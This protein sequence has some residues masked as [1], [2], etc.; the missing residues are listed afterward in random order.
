MSDIKPS[1]LRIYI[2]NFKSLCKD[3]DLETPINEPLEQLLPFDQYLKY[4]ESKEISTR[5]GRH[6]A[7]LYF[8]KKNNE[9]KRY[10]KKLEEY[11]DIIKENYPKKTD[12]GKS[13]S[14]LQPEMNKYMTLYDS[15]LSKFRSD[16]ST[17]NFIFLWVLYPLKDPNMPASRNIL[18]SVRYGKFKSGN[19][20]SPRDK[21]LYLRDHKSDKYH[22]D[23]DIDVPLE[24]A[25]I[26]HNYARAR[27]IKAGDMLIDRSYSYI[28]N[29]LKSNGLTVRSVRNF[30]VKYHEGEI[31]RILAKRAKQRGQ[32]VNTAL[33][34][35]SY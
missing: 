26:I 17:D 23:I 5:K 32:T 7:Y 28:K 24:F 22:G 35:Y 20:Y 14:D 19:Y 25:K 8:A 15:Y 21:Q 18:S 6:F 11:S 12:E 31:Y 3:L 27:K 34:Y 10:I 1:T 33:N 29:I 30:Q 9:S 13:Q 2:S 4:L 16:P